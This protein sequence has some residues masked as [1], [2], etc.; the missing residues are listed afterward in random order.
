MGEFRLWLR[1]RDVRLVPL[2][3]TDAQQV[4]ATRA[5]GADQRRVLRRHEEMEAA[6]IA[7]VEEGLA[8]PDWSGVLYVMGWGSTIETFTPLYI[9]KAARRGKKNALSVNLRNLRSDKGKFARWG[10]GRA[11]HVGDLSAALFGQATGN[12]TAKYQRWVEMLFVEHEPPRLRAP[13]YL[14]LVP[15]YSGSVAPSGALRSVEDTEA[16][17]ID[18]AL[19]E[20]EQ[21]VLN[22]VAETWWAPAAS[23]AARPPGAH[24]PRRPIRMI[25]DDIGVCGLATELAREEVVSLDVETDMWTQR[26]SL[27][28]IGTGAYTAII[29][30]FR[31]SIEPLAVVL[32][33]Q[34]PVKVIHNASFERRVLGEVGIGIG[35]VV[36]TLEWSRAHH[37]PRTAGSH[38]LAALC[39]RELGVVLDK[40]AQTSAWSSRPLTA[41]QVA[42]AACDAEVLIDLYG[43]IL[44]RERQ[45]ALF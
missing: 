3:A 11:Y 44:S 26:L 28:Q 14:A 7:T 40:A 38:S 15:W 30:P 5:V 36:D 37:A 31:A 1:K 24:E 8:R 4:A 33:A 29:D 13:T 35:G 42:Y 25:D 39:K 43:V 10:D 32:A 2:F 22:A 9:G 34:K 41:A 23:R 16:E 20:Y 21:S 27:V 45:T 18:L 6:V 12:A 19:A 17:L